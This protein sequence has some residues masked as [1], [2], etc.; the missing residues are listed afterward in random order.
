[1]RNRDNTF[2]TKK[3]ITDSLLILLKS[4]SYNSITIAEITTK[5]GVNRSTYYR[6]FIS[7][8]DIIKQYYEILLIT[9]YSTISD[10]NIKL[11]DYLFKM[12]SFFYSQRNDLLLLHRHCLSYLLLDAL[13]DKFCSNKQ[14]KNFNDSFSIYYHTGGIFN[15][16]LLWFNN[17]MNKTPQQMTDYSTK[18][19]PENF[20]PLLKENNTYI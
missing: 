20:I 17:D 10:E 1:M 11:E 14:V 6:N 4:K 2:T 9:F 12:F 5:A 18:V 7:K 15:T 16:F 19:L 13:N 3:Y 8:D